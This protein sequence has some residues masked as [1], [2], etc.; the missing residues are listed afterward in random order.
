[1]PARREGPRALGVGATRRT[2]RPAAMDRGSDRVL[3]E[4]RRRARCSARTPATPMSDEPTTA[5][6]RRVLGAPPDVVFGQW[7]DPAALREWMCPRPAY[8]T[9]IDVD[10]RVGGRLRFDIIDEGTQL[11]VTGEF[12]V[13]DRPH[14]LEFTWDCSTWPE[15]SAPSVVTVT[16]EPHARE[17]T[18]MT[19]D[20][21]RLP[22]GTVDQHARGWTLIA[23]QLGARHGA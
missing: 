17:E 7:I 22:P 20:H 21:T 11:V 14:R 6:V 1:R 13:V 19:I 23:S 18:L 15:G 4:A 10:P 8:A 9:S 12:L 16:L 5:T 3:V 2:A